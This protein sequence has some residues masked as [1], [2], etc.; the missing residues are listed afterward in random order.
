MS[1]HS[2]PA[3]AT[4][5]SLSRYLDVLTGELSDLHQRGLLPPECVTDGTWNQNSWLHSRVLGALV[6]AVE[7]PLVP[8]VEVGWSRNFCPDLCIIDESDTVQAVI[9]YESTNSSDERLFGKDIWHFEEA[10]LAEAPNGKE[11]PPWWVLISTLPSC[12]VKNWPWYEWNTLTDYAPAVK[13]R[14]QR[15]ACPLGY[16]EAGLH[17]AFAVTWNKV[18]SAFGDNRLVNLAWVNLDET[19]TFTTKNLNGRAASG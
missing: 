14:N 19:L 8:L 9:E 13:D 4:A 17:A 1:R 3:T 12:K 5:F 11:L 2:N 10:I 16:Y 18:A 15:N 7:R 6:R